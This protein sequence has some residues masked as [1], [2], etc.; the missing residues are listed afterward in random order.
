M[1]C[2]YMITGGNTTSRGLILEQ[3][4][5]EPVPREIFLYKLSNIY[6]FQEQIED[7]LLVINIMVDDNKRNLFRSLA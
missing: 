6:L 3:Q 4:Y 7:E 2:A 1:K 5:Q